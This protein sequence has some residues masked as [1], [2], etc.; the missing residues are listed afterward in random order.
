MFGALLAIAAF[1]YYGVPLLVIPFYQDRPAQTERLFDAFASALNAYRVD[2]GAYPPV[3]TLNKYR[4][5]TNNLLRSRSFGVTTIRL[6][7]LTTP[8]AYLGGEPVG[9]P[10]ASPDQYA[11][12][13]YFVAMIDGE[14]TAVLSS[15]G[16]NLVYDL[17]S[18]L[19]RDDTTTQTLG[20]SL[21]LQLY[22]P[23]NGTRGG[24]D[25]IRVV[26]PRARPADR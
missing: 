5:Q 1:T 7:A 26:S 20:A 2:H 8:V 22:D 10:Y 11:P 13:A 12:P 18:L 6:S 23:T 25:M 19:E 21:K 15:P 3:D 4:K 16:P 14:E 9:D 17:R 24:G